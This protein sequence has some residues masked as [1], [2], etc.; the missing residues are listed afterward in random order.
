MIRNFFPSKFGEFEIMNF[1][2]ISQ[3]HIL[4]S[5]F[6]AILQKITINDDLRRSWFLLMGRMP[7]FYMEKK[8]S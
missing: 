3:N 8:W 1:F 6:G 2:Y 4:W 5:K 7:S